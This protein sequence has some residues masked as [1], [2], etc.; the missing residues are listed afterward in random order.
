LK[1]HYNVTGI[2]TLYFIDKSSSEYA[3]FNDKDDG[4]SGKSLVEKLAAKNKK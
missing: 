4:K 2:P 3:T 1:K